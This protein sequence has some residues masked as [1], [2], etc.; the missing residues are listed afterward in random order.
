MLKPHLKGKP[1]FEDYVRLSR[2]SNVTIGVNRYP[3]FNYPINHPGTYSRLRDIEAPMLG[4]CYL[5]EWTEGL[6]QLYDLDKE[7]FTYNSIDELFAKSEVL[8]KDKNLRQ[9]LRVNGQKRS[10]SD[11]SIPTLLKKIIGVNGTK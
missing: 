11:H 2:E 7:I 8:M 5:T 1:N 4:A 10:L 9:S 6:D 3:S